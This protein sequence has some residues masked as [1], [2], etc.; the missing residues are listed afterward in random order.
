MCRESTNVRPGHPQQHADMLQTCGTHMRWHV[1]IRPCSPHI[2]TTQSPPCTPT[3]W[4]GQA[5]RC[6][7]GRHPHSGQGGLDNSVGAACIL[8]FSLTCLPARHRYG[9]NHNLQKAQQRS[10]RQHFL[11]NS[12]SPNSLH[13]RAGAACSISGFLCTNL[14]RSAVCTWAPRGL[15]PWHGQKW[16]LV[17]Y[18]V[19]SG[20]HSIWHHCKRW[21]KDNRWPSKAL[22]YSPVSATGEDSIGDQHH[23]RSES[24]QKIITRDLENKCNH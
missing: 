17:S 19:T 5:P 20:D 14:A 23:Q 18:S 4:S 7:G 6:W 24:E 1:L 2:S 10:P 9:S 21:P 11:S 3:G 16:P 15:K 8:F 13:S 22:L 12:V